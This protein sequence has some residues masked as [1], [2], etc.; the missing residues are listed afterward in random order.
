MSRSPRPPSLTPRRPPPYSR[1]MSTIDRSRDQSYIDSARLIQDLRRALIAEGHEKL[2]L[3]D[4]VRRLE[5]S[6]S[7]WIY[8]AGVFALTAAVASMVIATDDSPRRAED[9][10]AALASTRAEWSRHQALDEERTLDYSRRL[11]SADTATH[12][13]LAAYA[14]EIEEAVALSLENDRLRAALETARRQPSTTPAPAPADLTPAAGDRRELQTGPNQAPMTP[15]EFSS[16]QLSPGTLTISPDDAKTNW[17][18]GQAA[19]PFIRFGTTAATF[20]A[21]AGSRTVRSWAQPGPDTRDPP[22]PTSYEAARAPAGDLGSH[23]ADDAL[24]SGELT[25]ALGGADCPD[26]LLRRPCD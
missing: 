3:E 13:V 2:A 4:R 18:R 8:A 6:R 26:A 16:G 11:D 9:A 10:T 15:Q 17:W 20:S 23:Y 21:V 25:P 22:W 14:D 5:I 24:R 7:L 19:G 1:P 12:R